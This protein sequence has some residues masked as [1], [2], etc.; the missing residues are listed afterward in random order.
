MMTSVFRVCFPHCPKDVSRGQDYVTV[1]ENIQ[2]SGIFMHVSV[3]CKRKISDSYKEVVECNDVLSWRFG[4]IIIDLPYLKPF[5]DFICTLTVNCYN[6]LPYITCWWYLL[7]GP[8]DRLDFW[9]DEDC[10]ICFK[11]LQKVLR[12]TWDCFRLPSRSTFCPAQNFLQ[13]WRLI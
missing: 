4:N 8:I 3:L 2:T 11:A 10:E 6:C 13:F 5:F 9:C 12:G 1:T 7:I